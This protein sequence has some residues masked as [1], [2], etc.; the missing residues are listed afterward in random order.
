MSWTKRLI[1]ITLLYIAGF[2][3]LAAMPPTPGVTNNNYY[4]LRD[5]MFKSDVE[6]LLDG[7]SHEFS[8]IPQRGVINFFLT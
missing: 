8:T 6:T 2:F 3:V 4:R 5:G 1:G 7:P